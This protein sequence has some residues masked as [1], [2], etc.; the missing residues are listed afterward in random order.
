[1]TAYNVEYSYMVEEFGVT[2][3]NADDIEQAEMFGKEY[4]QETYPEASSVTIDSV[5]EI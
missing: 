5:K 3:I 1:M 2:A 4:V